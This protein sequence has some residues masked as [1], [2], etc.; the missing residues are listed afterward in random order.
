MYGKSFSQVL[1]RKPTRIKLRNKT[2]KNIKKNEG[3][4][5]M[6]FMVY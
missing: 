3:K 4:N 1:G 6:F 2:M 5:F